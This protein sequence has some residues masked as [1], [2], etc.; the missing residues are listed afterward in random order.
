MF[1][2]NEIRHYAKIQEN[3][4]IHINLIENQSD[5]SNEFTEETVVLNEKKEIKISNKP[6][7]IKA[8]ETVKPKENNKNIEKEVVKTENIDSK[9]ESEKSEVASG[10]N[11]NTG[12]V[13]DNLDE[14]IIFDSNGQKIGANQNI[15]GINYRILSYKDPKYP[16][17][18][19]KF[20]LKDKVTVKTRFLVGMD[21]EIENIEIIEGPEK[22]GFTN[23]VLESLKEWKFSPVQYKGQTIKLYFY[24]DFIF[25]VE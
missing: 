17:I 22:F 24:K 18:A 2:S 3:K 8:V 14:G 13:G 16:I 15:A 23:A 7:E 9:S 1:Y 6:V 11:Q 4:E 21:G 5:V 19:K 25:K 12:E 10:K 20:K